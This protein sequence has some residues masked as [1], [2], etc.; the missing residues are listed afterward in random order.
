MS[1]K[2]TVDFTKMHGIGNDYVYIDCFKNP[3]PQAIEQLAIA[4]S[5]RHTGVGGD[6]IILVEPATTADADCRMRIFNADGS[7]AMMCGNGV[8]CVA[9]YYHDHINPDVTTVRVDTLSGVKPIRLIFKDGEVVGA[10]V[11]MG[12]PILAPA[13]VPVRFE[14]DVMQEAP[15]ETRGGV[16]R[17]TAVSM[18]NPHGVIFLDTLEGFDV[19]GIGRELEVH[20]MWPNRANI[21]FAAVRPG[22]DGRD[23][24]MRVW[25]RGSGETMACG[26]G[27]CATAIAAMLTKRS[28]RRVTIHLLGGDLEI[29]WADNGHVMMT[30]PAAEVFTG[31]YLRTDCPAQS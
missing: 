2:T 20:P 24:D 8:R 29:E 3:E 5:D 4:M 31:T 12:E 19:H 22:T 30:G 18:G 1:T 10:T 9:K 11:D 27:S 21:E 25:E 26:T 13:E 23:I 14:G 16:L 6:G 28:P 7:E 17:M 15:V